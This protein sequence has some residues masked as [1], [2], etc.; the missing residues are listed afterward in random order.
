MYLN[1]FR[2][3]VIIVIFSTLYFNSYYLVLFG[4]AIY[5]NSAI[6]S[7]IIKILVDLLDNIG[8]NVFCWPNLVVKNFR[9]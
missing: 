5:F 6:K 7:K 9:M 2:L 3:A 8:L 4:C 1:I